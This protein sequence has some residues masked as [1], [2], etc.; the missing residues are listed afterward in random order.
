MTLKIAEEISLGNPSFRGGF[1]CAAPVVANGD[2]ETRCAYRLTA[3]VLC[4]VV[5]VEKA[6]LPLFVKAEEPR[7]LFLL[8]AARIVAVVAGRGH[9]MSRGANEIGSSSSHANP[10]IGFGTRRRCFH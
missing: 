4:G 2:S 7:R 5:Q 6:S 3:R 1:F 8:C 9:P 10:G